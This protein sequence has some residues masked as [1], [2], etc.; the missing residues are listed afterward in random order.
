MDFS[1]DQDYWFLRRHSVAFSEMHC[2]FLGIFYCNESLFGKYV[3]QEVR[4]LEISRIIGWPLSFL[5]LT[6]VYHVDIW[7]KKEQRHQTTGLAF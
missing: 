5:N 1:Q 4:D 3:K 7:Q 6:L 2:H